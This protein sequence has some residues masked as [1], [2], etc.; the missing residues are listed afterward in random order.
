M[1]A[2]EIAKEIEKEYE[3]EMLQPFPNEDFNSLYAIDPLNWEGFPIYFDLYSSD[4][5]GYASSASRFLRK[6]REEIEL[7]REAIRL[8]FFE[9]YPQYASFLPHITRSATPKL[10]DE[11]EAVEKVRLHLLALFNLLLD[12]RPN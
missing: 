2:K 1:N 5:A 7:T 11:M 8:S 6:T 10:L 12:E 9:A 4:V 3:A